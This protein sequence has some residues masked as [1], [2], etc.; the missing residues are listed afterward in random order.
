MTPTTFATQN[1]RP[2][3]QLRAWQ[4]WFAPVFDISP[5]E[6]AE[7]GFSAKN[8]VWSL[9]DISISRV[10]A[11]SV[12]V[13][14]AKANL[15][16]APIDHWVLTY[17]RQGVTKVQTP[18]GEF[19]AAGG[20]PFLWS[21]GEQF[22]SKRTRVDRTQILLSREAFHDLAP[23]LDAARGAVL[24]KPWGGLLGDYILAVER[25]LPLM[26]ESD[27]PRLTAAVRN[28]VAACIA[29]S[30]EHGFLAREEIDCGL[31]ERVRRIIQA[32]LQSLQLQPAVLCRMLGISRSQLYRLFERTGGVAHYIQRQRLL[33]VCAVLSDPANQ[34]PIAAIAA[35]FCFEDASSFSRAFRQE[36]GCSPSEVRS[37]A[38]VGIPLVATRRNEM[39]AEV[40]RFADLFTVFRD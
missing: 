9:G 20:V 14:R 1:L 32:Q 21:L 18:K 26:K 8:I 33:R 31:L 15:A 17:C 37:A 16:K 7:E 39:K 5:M 35:D 23:L 25:W 13:K 27:A 40:V 29:P 34:R 38:K 10:S 2:R 11:A 24:E 36:F 22:E 30:A 4:E 12:H 19:D 3:D 6:Q 28:M